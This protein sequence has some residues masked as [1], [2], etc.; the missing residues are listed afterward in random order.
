MK[1]ITRNILIGLPIAA[2][3]TFGGSLA[4]LRG[5]YHGIALQRHAEHIGSV[6]LTLLGCDDRPGLHVIYNAGTWELFPGL[7]PDPK[8]A[9]SYFHASQSV[10]SH[11]KVQVDNGNTACNGRVRT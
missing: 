4:Y 7:A 5:M 2:G 6:D 3:L 10:V 11:I 1:N 9:L 8:T